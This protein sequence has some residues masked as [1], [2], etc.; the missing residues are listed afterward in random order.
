MAASAHEGWV[1]K[2]EHER[3][4]EELR[5]ANRR[6]SGTLQIVLDTLDSQNVAMLFSRV[7]EEISN[8]MDAWG[9]TVYLAEPDGYHLRGVSERLQGVRISRFFSFGRTLDALAAHAGRTLRLRV[10]SPDKDELRQGRL[11]ARSVLDEAT[12]EVHRVGIE[13]L[14]PFQSFYAVPVW[15]GNHVVALIEVGWQRV[16]PLSQDDADLLDAVAQYLSVQ[17][18]GAFSALRTQREGRLRDVSSQMREELLA[19]TELSE[20]AIH[21]A[22]ARAAQELSAQ[23]SPVHENVHQ[24]TVVANLPLS[25]LCSAPLDLPM[26]AS[27]TDALEDA[28][29]VVAITEDTSLSQWLDEQG[30]PC[31][32][33][34]LDAGKVAGQRCACLFLRELDE[35]PFDD[36][37]LGFLKALGRDVVA[38]ARGEEARAY[39]RR[40]S[41][42]LQTGMKNE[43]QLVE[44]ITSEGSYSSATA[45]AFVGGDFYDLIR[46]PGRRACVIMGDV[47]GKGV[48][49]ASVSAA[50]KTAL[51][52][53]AWE[54]LRPAQMV[55]LLND[56]LLGFSRLETFA[57]L[58]VGV[59]D[60]GKRSLT[61]CSAG[62]PP[63]IL[64][65]AKSRELQMLEIQ[66]G[67]VGA[68]KEMTYR[69]GVVTLGVGDILLLYTDGTTEARARDGRFFGEDGLRD[70]VM[71]HAGGGVPGL[72]ASLLAELDAFTD[73]TLEDD[74]ALVALRFDEVG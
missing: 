57:T 2:E 61:Y 59:I 45:A 39:D 48:E 49:A 44:G 66:S 60:L 18:V 53:Y 25:G 70:A 65:R 4:V 52:A 3:V 6:L 63:A 24:H 19:H 36:L 37:E 46:L 64:L 34:L 55:R 14:P 13:A 20:K 51:A 54:G 35:E 33:A 29:A 15:F 56:F 72:C 5:R 23:M 58:F 32:G 41:Q 21:A 40:I 8:T 16:H 50:V 1:P 31:I 43:L 69:N 42:A 74:V 71:R 27:A 26:V 9:T 11:S 7:L 22:F 73:R 62:H 68:F 10:Q 12:G 38:A 67:V 17:L 30:E 47:S 28:V